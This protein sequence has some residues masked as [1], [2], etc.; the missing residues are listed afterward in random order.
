[1]RTKYKWWVAAVAGGITAGAVVAFFVLKRGAVLQ[2]QAIGLRQALE[3][4]G[5]NI[6]LALTARGETLA[7]EIGREAEE[8][9][10]RRAQEA[11]DSHIGERYY[12]TPEN[13][14]KLER[15]GRLF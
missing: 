10:R 3:G 1:M 7:A 15:L 14:A 6:E 12:L 8:L 2:L 13:M 5:S 4:G 11:A 9:V